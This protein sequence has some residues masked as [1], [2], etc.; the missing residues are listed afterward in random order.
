MKRFVIGVSGGIAA[1]KSEFI[2]VL[3]ERLTASVTSFGDFV[4]T[5]AAARNLDASSRDVLQRFGEQLKRDLGDQAFVEQVLARVEG[6][7]HV[8]VDGVRHVEV[9]DAIA[10]AVRPRC[11]VLVFLD[12]DIETRQVRAH[13][14]LTLDAGHLDTLDSHSTERQVHDGSLRTRADVVLDATQPIA[15]LV[16]EAVSRLGTYH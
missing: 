13:A 14:R 16:E 9:A 10:R 6:D 11:F 5:E 4:R 15:D 2:R 3:A 12:A 1:G 7:G 8:I